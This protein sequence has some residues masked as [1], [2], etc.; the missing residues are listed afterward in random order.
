MRILSLFLL[1]ALLAVPAMAQNN[2]DPSAARPQ[3]GQPTVD[4]RIDRLTG[5]LDLTPAQQAD[6]RRLME[7]HQ[8]ETAALR[9]QHQTQRQ[10]WR[11]AMD[12]RRQAMRAEMQEILT[13]EQAAKLDSLQQRMRDRRHH[14]PRHH[15]RHGMDGRRGA[16]RPN[17]SRSPRYLGPPTPADSTQQ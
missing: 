6:V 14:A 7:A 12:A 16:D 8:A 9:E 10:A 2:A 13:D 5:A 3:R 11:E 17:R 15:G 1:A 4:Q